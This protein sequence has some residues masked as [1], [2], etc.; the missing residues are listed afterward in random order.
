MTDRTTET[1]QLPAC[2]TLAA[3]RDT[4]NEAVWAAWAVEAQDTV[5]AT[6]A[7]EADMTDMGDSRVSAL[8]VPLACLCP[9]TTV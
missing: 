3:K 8:K 9:M 2:A 5:D 6:V 1:V 7:A 4:S